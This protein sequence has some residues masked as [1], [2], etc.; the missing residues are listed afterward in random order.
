MSLTYENFYAITTLSSPTKILH[1]KHVFMVNII[2]RASVIVKKNQL[3][4]DKSFMPTF[5]VRCKLY[6]LAV[7]DFLYCSKMISRISVTFDL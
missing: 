2:D 6:R 3:N 4:V 5:A 7:R 1:V